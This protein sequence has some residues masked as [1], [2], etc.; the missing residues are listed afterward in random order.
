MLPRISISTISGPIQTIHTRPPCRLVRSRR[1]TASI[2]PRFMALWQRT[3]RPPP[4]AGAN[5]IQNGS[6]TPGADAADVITLSSGST[7]ITDWTVTAGSVDDIRP[8]Y[9]Q[10]P[11]GGHTLDMSGT[12][13]GTIDQT[14]ATTA[15]V[16]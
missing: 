4:A 6:F 3:L 10:S 9:W 2:L 1:R 16:Q 8:T 14:F 13:A 15:G 11:D 7:A 12:S 5:L